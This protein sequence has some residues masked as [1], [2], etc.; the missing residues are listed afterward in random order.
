MTP[1]NYITPCKNNKLH[2]LHDTNINILL[3]YLE[4]NS[5][6]VPVKI[7][8]VTLLLQFTTKLPFLGNI[9]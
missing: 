4:T 6:L 7:S 9:T 1:T 2:G 5:H 3:G 8:I